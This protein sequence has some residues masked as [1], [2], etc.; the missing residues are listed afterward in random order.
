MEGVN[1]LLRNHHFSA[2]L[3]QIRADAAQILVSALWISSTPDAGAREGC[4]S[5]FI[6]GR[7]ANMRFAVSLIMFALAGC[8]WIANPYELPP[9]IA[10][11]AAAVAQDRKDCAAG[12]QSACAD[13]QARIAYCREQSKPVSDGKALPFADPYACVGIDL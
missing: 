12:K 4:S 2:A 5:R 3:H 8:G 13:Y 7:L 11:V 1:H 6:D 9:G 10:A